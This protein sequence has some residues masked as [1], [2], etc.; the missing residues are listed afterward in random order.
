MLD[1]GKE[2]KKRYDERVRKKHEHFDK[3]LSA[4]LTVDDTHR[5]ITENTRVVMGVCFEKKT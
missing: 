5:T 3:E 1:T 4:S 2:W